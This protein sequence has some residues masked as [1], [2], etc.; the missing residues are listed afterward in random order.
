MAAMTLEE[1][2]QRLRFIM[3]AIE[4]AAA[5]GNSAQAIRLLKEHATLSRERDLK[6]ERAP[7]EATPKAESA[8]HG[9][10]EATLLLRVIAALRKLYPNGRPQLELEAIHRACEKELALKKFSPKTLGRAI[11]VAWK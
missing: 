4:A 1:V 3:P 9:R 7:I 5:T 11:K 8:P 2:E 6:L 10:R